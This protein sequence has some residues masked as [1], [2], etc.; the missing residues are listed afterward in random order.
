M[1][2]HSNSNFVDLIDVKT[3]ANHSQ[4]GIKQSQLGFIPVCE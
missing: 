1:I 3:L 4:T 2:P